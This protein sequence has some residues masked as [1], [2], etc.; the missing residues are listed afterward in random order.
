MAYG[1]KLTFLGLIMLEFKLKEVPMKEVFAVGPIQK[2]AILGMPFLYTHQCS[3]VFR[4]PEVYI[5][6][7]RIS[8]AKKFGQ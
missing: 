5:N 6:G 1:T 8:C 2:D 7:R 4:T 3:M